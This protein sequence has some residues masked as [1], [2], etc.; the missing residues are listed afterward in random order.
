MRRRGI[1]E[2]RWRHGV[3]TP[4]LLVVMMI[5]A[6]MMSSERST[7]TLIGRPHVAALLVSVALVEVWRGLRWHVLGRAAVHLVYLARR[8]YDLLQVALVVQRELKAQQLAGVGLYLLTVASDLDRLVEVEHV[9]DVS[10]LGEAQLVLAQPIDL[11]NPTKGTSIHTG[12][13]LPGNW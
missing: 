3:G 8:L 6:T 9:V 5:S 10:G 13:K 11:K 12:R 4:T 2:V 7:V 1:V